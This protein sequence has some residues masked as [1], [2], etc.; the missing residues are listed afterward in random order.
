MDRL[1]LTTPNRGR[2]KQR[3]VPVRATLL[4]LLG[5][6]VFAVVLPWLLR[7]LV[8]PVQAS[9]DSQYNAGVGTM[10]ALL[11]GQIFLR[12][13]TNFPGIR[14]S[15]YVIPTFAISY[16]AVLA[17]F[18][19]LRLDY[20]RIQFIASFALCI[21]WYV[22][23]LHYRQRSVMLEI[24]IVPGGGTR[25]LQLIDGVS[26][27][28][29]DQ[30]I[31]LREMRVDGIV[32]DLR[33]DLPVEWERFLA[34]SALSGVPVYHHKQIAE[35]LTGRV[36]IE[37]LSENNFGSLI[38]GLAYVTIKFVTDFVAAVVAAIVLAPV[39]AVAAFAIRLDSPGPIL[40]RQQRMGY[41]GEP[42]TVFKFR[43]MT[44]R[45]EAQPSDWRHDAITRVGDDRITRVGHFL[46]RSRID[47][48]PQIANILRGEMSWIG[49]RPEAVVLS[50]WYERELPFYRYRH[51]VRPGITGW[52]Q[53]NQGHVAEVDEV[54]W[55][56]HFD[57][58]YIKYFTPWLDLLIA[59][60]TVNTILTG[61]GSK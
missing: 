26:W 9:L 55:K 58:Y 25:E 4:Q 1:L 56:L 42:F 36:E 48:L 14:G 35:S 47:E 11:G 17:I 39:M 44:D 7:I 41:R 3:R 29:L 43:T 16:G 53:V 19:F 8:E 40:F 24:G 38:P 23:M 28:P 49:P 13:L 6:I 2:V 33:A 5:V 18:F 20:S 37:H 22:L 31:A 51:I 32:A 50:E 59:F 21:I 61:F 34:E 45:R 46:R 10:A 60:R 12:S 15:K 52:A 30:P 57:F 27:I 54:L